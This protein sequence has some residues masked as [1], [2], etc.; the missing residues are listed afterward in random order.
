VKSEDDEEITVKWEAEKVLRI[1]P[2]DPI[3]GLKSKR[4]RDLGRK[5]LAL[6][7]SI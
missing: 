4:L 2:A 6:K 5:D 7:M 3:E 1:P